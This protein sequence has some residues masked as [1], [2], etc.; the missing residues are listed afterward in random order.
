VC[1]ADGKKPAYKRWW[2][3]LMMVFA[4]LVLVLVIATAAAAR[5]TESNKFCSTTCHEMVPYG[6]SWAQSKHHQVDCVTCHIQ[7]GVWNLVKA[8]FYALREVY[9]HVTGEVKAPI[10]VTRHI[11]NATCQKSGCHPASTPIPE[12]SLG[13]STFSH[14][15]HAGQLC[16]ACHSRVVHQ[17]VPG[18]TYVAPQSMAACFA[19]HDGK[20]QPNDCA[21]C[22]T[23]PHADRGPCGACHVLASWTAKYVHPVLLGVRHV[24]VVCERCHVKDFTS[25][26]TG[27]T[28]C[29]KKKHGPKL[30]DC[31]QCH[32]LTRFK[33]ST[34]DHPQAGCQDCHKAAH[35]NRGTC[36]KCHDTRNWIS[37]FKHPWPLVGAHARLACEKCHK[38]G[39]SGG[40]PQTCVGCHGSHHA[41]L[42]DCQKCHN[43]SYWI[44]ASFNHP[45]ALTGAHASLDC[46]RCHTN[47][48]GGGLPQ[49]CVGCHGDHHGGLPNCQSCHTTSAWS[50]STFH[51]PQEGPHIPS[52]DE[53]LACSRCHPSGYGTHSC[54]CHGGGPPSGGD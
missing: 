18:W 33:P 27:C 14:S 32:T 16:I 42:T 20:Q 15:G 3:R 1:V 38:N 9:V 43:T 31:A 4:A 13:T 12:I 48:F 44:P 22:H 37:H 41:G 21:Y 50:P 28:S 17:N 11:V 49:A 52:G 24:K 26:P 51:H 35:P 10:S 39:F 54:P 19:C 6:M 53:P 5:Y 40:L 45:F 7:P 8:K 36:T 23:A 25:L 29:H 2:A 46:S 47:G 30:P 34:F